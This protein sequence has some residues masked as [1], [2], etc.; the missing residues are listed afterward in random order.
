LFAE[1]FLDR[2]EESGVE[3]AG[4]FRD[5]PQRHPPQLESFLDGL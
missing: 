3:Y 5:G 2:L 1:F 4:G